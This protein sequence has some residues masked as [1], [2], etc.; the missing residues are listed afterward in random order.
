MSKASALNLLASKMPK[1]S[2]NI[3]L[4]D[5]SEVDVGSNLEESDQGSLPAKE[6]TKI[7]K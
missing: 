7:P 5:S 4:L 6:G 2:A 1:G 3:S